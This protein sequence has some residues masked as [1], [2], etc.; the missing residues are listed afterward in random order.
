MKKNQEAKIVGAWKFTLTDINTG[1]KAIKEYKNLITTVG[2]GVLMDAL[3][4][5]TPA[6]SPLITHAVLGSDDTAVNI[7]DTALGNETYRNTIASA[8]SVGNIA[9]LTAFFTA[10]ECSGTYKEA[11]L[12]IDGTGEDILFNHLNIDVVKTTTQTLT[13]DITL[14]T[15]NA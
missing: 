14:T 8:T 3:A 6:C 15:I 5:A 12:I 7:A 9:Y 1:E 2:L 11:G 4:N 13:I 10:L